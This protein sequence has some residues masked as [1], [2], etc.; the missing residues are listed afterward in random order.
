VVV[1]VLMVLLLGLGGS[2]GCAWPGRTT[3]TKGAMG[4]E[5]RGRLGVVMLGGA[6]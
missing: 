1:V 2:A 4:K 5:M 6:M 3:R